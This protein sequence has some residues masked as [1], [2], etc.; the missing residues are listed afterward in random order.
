MGSG[1]YTAMAGAVAQ[2][3]AL[4]TVA[5]NISNAST[6]GYRAER[7]RF[8]EALTRAKSKAT[9]YV[10]AKSG[11]TDTTPGART[12][13]GNTFDLALVNDGYFSVQTKQGLR[14]TRAGNFSIDPAGQLVTADGHPVL[15]QGGKP[16]KLGTDPTLLSTVAVRADGSIAAGDQVLGQLDI[17]NYR[18]EQLQRQGASLFAPKGAPV[19]GPKSEV[20]VG[21]IERGNF[22]VVRGMVDLVKI[23]RSYEALHR[24]L[25]GYREL[26]DRIARATQ[27]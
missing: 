11:V 7:C 10:Q 18:P 14:V 22:D 26:D 27:G 1:I 8:G 2:S 21:Q 13:T 5:N 17:R 19:E 25:E 6:T 16:I 23:S 20:A 9:A 4:D 15:G 24:M 3:D 12:E